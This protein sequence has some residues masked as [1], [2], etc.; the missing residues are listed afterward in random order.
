MATKVVILRADG[1]G[2]NAGIDIKEMQSTEG[3]EHLLGSGAAC[4]AA[5]E[6]TMLRIPGQLV[7]AHRGAS[8]L[9]PEHTIAAYDL[10]LHGA[11]PRAPMAL[12]RDMEEDTPLGHVPG[13]QFPAGFGH[14]AGHYA[15]GYYSYLWSDTLTADAA[16][17]FTEATGFYDPEVA[18]RLRQYVF[19]VGNTIDPAE[20][21][22]QFRGRE[23]AIGALMRKRGFPQ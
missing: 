4:F 23:A 14:I 10:A 16:E 1:K 2:F 20:G 9:L 18:R 6:A 12:W 17:A 11:R 5:F 19:S 7:I 13:S 8:G 15:G 21:Y 22:K 3:F